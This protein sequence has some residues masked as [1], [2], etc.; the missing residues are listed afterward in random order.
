M[1]SVTNGIGSPG[2]R[3]RMPLRTGSAFVSI[4]GDPAASTPSGFFGTSGIFAA[5]ARGVTTYGSLKQSL[6][7]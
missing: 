6:F 7:W 3:R 5:K 2:T 4:V 1:N